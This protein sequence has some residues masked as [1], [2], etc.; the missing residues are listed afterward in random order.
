MKI[1]EIGAEA[2]HDYL[3]REFRFQGIAQATL[4]SMLCEQIRAAVYLFTVNSP[5]N[6]SVS[7]LKVVRTVCQKAA[8]L[9]P[10]L[11]YGDWPE[12]LIKRELRLLIELKDLVEDD[13]LGV[14]L[15]P[16]RLIPADLGVFLMIG[17]GPSQLLPY[18]IRTEL[19]IFGRARIVTPS[20]NNRQFIESLPKQTAE[21]WLASTG[22]T[23]FAWHDAYLKAAVR[24]MTAAVE[25]GH[26]EAFEDGFFR[27]LANVRDT[28]KPL[29]VRF[30]T[31]SSFKH[32]YGL[33]SCVSSDGKR[34][35]D[36]FADIDYND[37]QRLRGIW[38]RDGVPARLEFAKCNG[39]LQLNVGYPLPKPEA[40]FLSLGWFIKSKSPS[41]WP[42]HYYFPQPTFPLIE[43]AAIALGFQMIEVPRIRKNHE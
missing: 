42:H 14:S 30:R 3:A 27:Q 18:E 1:E 8:P 28:G 43:T 24:R 10:A 26:M 20:P 34:V 40:Q 17:G 32:F 22:A 38:S 15:A 12:D 16:C 33:A 13:E 11:G 19:Q 35:I 23:P 5:S 2:A 4:I 29:F 36:K 25:L 21:S 39:L 9:M 37:A 6:S 31:N 7:K 41:G